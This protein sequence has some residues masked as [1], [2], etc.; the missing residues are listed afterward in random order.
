M[1]ARNPYGR[2]TGDD[3]ALQNDANAAAQAEAD[4]AKADARQAWKDA[5]SPQGAGAKQLD[6]D[7]SA[8][9]RA[10]QEKMK[11]NNDPG[12]IDEL[13]K[14]AAAAAKAEMGKLEA[15]VAAARQSLADATA[16]LR[17]ASRER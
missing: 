2:L 12:N 8:I 9:G 11:H 14:N 7:V 13:R 4:A 15:D 17:D 16:S 1:E 6:D 3:L 10:L 5:G